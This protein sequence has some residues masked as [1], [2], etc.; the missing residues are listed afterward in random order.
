MRKERRGHFQ[1]LGEHGII[2]ELG[3]SLLEKRVNTA[4]DQVMMFKLS[5]FLGPSNLEVPWLKKSLRIGSREF[6][7]GMDHVHVVSKMI[8]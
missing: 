8:E 5:Q 4:V 7:S 2:C 6:E 1:T 3:T